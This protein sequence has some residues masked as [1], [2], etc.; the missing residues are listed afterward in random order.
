MIAAFIFYLVTS[1]ILFSATVF[2]IGVHLKGWG[3]VV[4]LGIFAANVW[5]AASFWTDVAERG[6]PDGIV[7]RNDDHAG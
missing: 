1:L 3:V 5:A 7:Q 2:A 6:K 4:A